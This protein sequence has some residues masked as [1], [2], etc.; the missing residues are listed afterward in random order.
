MER[1]SEVQKKRLISSEKNKLAKI[2]V[3]LSKDDKKLS[4]GLISQA[5]FL[6]VSIDDLQNDINYYGYSVASPQ[7]VK[8]RPEADLHIAMCKNYQA[9]IK[10]LAEILG[11]KV[12]EIKNNTEIEFED[13]INDT[14]Q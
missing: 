10:Q 6:K 13:F 14:G 11:K 2:F 4:D 5:A 3:N 8:K 7:G 9:V 1:Y 12:K